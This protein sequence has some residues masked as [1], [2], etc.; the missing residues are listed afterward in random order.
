MKNQ[1]NRR[2]AIA[3]WNMPSGEIAKVTVSY[4]TVAGLTRA[5]SLHVQPM[6][7]EAG[8]G[9]TMERYEP[10]RGYWSTLEAAPRYSR[11]R[12]E[13]LAESPD[14]FTLARAMFALCTA[15]LG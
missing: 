12:L 10:R 15:D 3:A 2:I 11:K 8:D 9:Y 5:Y 14:T 4:P 6:T 13:A 1:D 7:L